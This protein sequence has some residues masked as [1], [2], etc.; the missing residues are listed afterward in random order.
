[1]VLEELVQVPVLKGLCCYPL[2]RSPTPT[3]IDSD[4][5][6]L[7]RS[8]TS[9]NFVSLLRK[10]N[11]VSCLK[12]DNPGTG[13]NLLGDSKSRSHTSVSVKQDSSDSDGETLKQSLFAKMKTQAD[14]LKKGG[15]IQKVL[16]SLSFIF[17]RHYSTLPA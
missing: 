9:S 8:P 4:G 3:A 14:A 7:R 16:I 1:M 6:S 10:L 12:A 11:C 17:P 2:N 15:Q 5:A 13:K